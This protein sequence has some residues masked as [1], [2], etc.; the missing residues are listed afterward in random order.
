MNIP[1]LWGVCVL[2]YQLGAQGTNNQIWKDLGAMVALKILQ[3]SPLHLWAFTFLFKVV[4][5]ALETLL[6][7]AL[8]SLC[9][10]SLWSSWEVSSKCLSERTACESIPF[11]HSNTEF[12]Q[13]LI[14]QTCRT[15]QRSWNDCQVPGECWL[16]DHKVTLVMVKYESDN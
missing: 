14:F 16:L 11:L 12:V 3:G 15:D 2:Y 8:S 1:I 4:W 13:H 7:E 10:L 5:K 6:P 9:I